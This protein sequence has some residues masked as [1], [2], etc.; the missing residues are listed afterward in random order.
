MLLS[1]FWVREKLLSLPA[2]E[3]LALAKKRIGNSNIKLIRDKNGIAQSK[4]QPGDICCHYDGKEEWHITLYVGDG[5]LADC[6]SSRKPNIKYG[7]AI[8][9]AYKIYPI[10]VAIRYTGK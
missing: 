1:S 2:D 5:K 3:A 8:T 9:G 4:L 10:K 6:T 7:Q